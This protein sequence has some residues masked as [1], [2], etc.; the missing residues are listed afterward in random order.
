MTTMSLENKKGYAWE[1][2]KTDAIISTNVVNRCVAIIARV[3]KIIA[4][5]TKV[6]PV[7]LRRYNNFNYLFSIKTL[8]PQWG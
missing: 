5:G 3:A 7:E 6:L 2:G 1:E 8:V 4:S